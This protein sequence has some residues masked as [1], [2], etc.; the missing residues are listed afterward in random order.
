MK[1]YEVQCDIHAFESF[2]LFQ[3]LIY[4]NTHIYTEYIQKHN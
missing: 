4:I 1:V 3:I 2:L